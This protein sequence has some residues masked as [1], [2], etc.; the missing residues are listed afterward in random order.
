MGFKIFGKTPFHRSQTV[1]L[2]TDLEFFD[3]LDQYYQ[4]KKDEAPVT[5]KD[6]ILAKVF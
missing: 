3:A 1:D 6:K 4:R 5:V 2:H